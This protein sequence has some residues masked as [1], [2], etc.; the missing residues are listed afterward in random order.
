MHPHDE[1]VCY[2]HDD[3]L[4]FCNILLMLHLRQKIHCRRNLRIDYLGSK[5]YQ[6]TSK[7]RYWS[8][9]IIMMKKKP[10]SMLG[11]CPICCSLEQARFGRTYFRFLYRMQRI[12]IRIVGGYCKC[13]Q[14]IKEAH[15]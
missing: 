2:S 3:F 4:L 7:E 14:D 1:A 5:Y 8:E 12:C 15:K 9:P 10:L 11:E 6:T 13:D